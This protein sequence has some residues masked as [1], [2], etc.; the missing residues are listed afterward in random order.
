M[1]ATAFA[2][3]Q[4]SFQ[5]KSYVKTTRLPSST[6]R[7][8]FGTDGPPTSRLTTPLT[9]Q[10]LYEFNS[11][12]M[13]WFTRPAKYIPDQASHQ[14]P[15]QH[16]QS[17][18]HPNQAKH[19]PPTLHH[20]HSTCQAH[21]QPLTSPQPHPTRSADHPPP[22]SHPPRPTRP[23]RPRSAD[24]PPPTSHPPRPTRPTRPAQLPP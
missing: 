23:T 4:C 10:P 2:C 16:H 6:D 8:A 21:H 22:T 14:H 19:L 20:P 5:K 17:P 3:T 15:P 9:A 24:H 11:I 18:H 7:G 13:T 1:P 12:S